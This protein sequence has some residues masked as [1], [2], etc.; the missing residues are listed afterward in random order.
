MPAK[1][2]RKSSPNVAPGVADVFLSRRAYADLAE[3][4]TYGTSHFGEATVAA[5]HDAFDQAFARLATYP[6]SG[7]A[8]P[9]FGVG[10]RCLVCGSHRILYRIE[11][12]VV[13]IVRVLHHSRDVPR[14]LPE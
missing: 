5:Y 2:S 9:G 10:L 8:R 4:D 6:L 12:Q 14:H 11:V 13:Q 7:E 3:I 1:S